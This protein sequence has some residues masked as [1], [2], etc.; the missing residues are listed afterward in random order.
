MSR[1]ATHALGLLA[2]LISTVP[3]V[4]DEAL[5]EQ[6]LEALQRQNEALQR[7]SETLQRQSET[8]QRQMQEVRAQ[9]RQLATEKRPAEKPEAVATGPQFSFGGQYR[10]NSYAVADDVGGDDRTASRVRVRQ[11]VDIKFSEQFKTHLQ[12]ELGHTTDNVTTTSTSSRG[13]DIAVRHAVLDYTFGNGANVQ[14]GIVP[15]SDRFDDTLFSSDWDYNPVALSLTAPLGGG[16]LR[17]FGANLNEGDETVAED[18]FVHYQLDYALPL[19]RDSQLHLGAT[20]ANLADPAQK[21]RI[22][23]NFG[24]GGSYWLRDGLLLRG[25]VVGS[26]T[27]KE[28]LGTRDDADGIA[29]KIELT[30]DGGLGVM[31]TYASG[32]SDGSGFLPP[33]ALAATQGYW[34]YTGLLTI[35]GPTDTGFDA[36]SV[37]ISNN[38]LGLTTVQVKYFRPLTANTDMYLA[39]GWFGASDTPAGRDS[40]VGFDFL[41]MGTYHFSDIL[42]LD[43]GAAY[44]LLGDAVSGY[45]NGVIGGVTFNQAAG[46]DRDKTAFFTRL[47]A[48]F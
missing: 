47:Q 41:A 1:S 9:L 22:H 10:V 16:T 27:E 34:G 7:Q 30:G 40:L 11:D 26:H 31:A 35:Q 44:A 6:R 38:G 2:L 33:M 43:F 3:A 25:F 13:N 42:A 46:D 18:D 23:A 45:P 36:D 28:L 29:A 4:A 37:N 48:E 14:A 39:A 19:P 5:L 24:I 15:L 8:M 20:L 12:L 32:E 17:A 21:D